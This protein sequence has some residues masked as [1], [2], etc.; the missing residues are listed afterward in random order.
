MKNKRWIEAAMERDKKERRKRLQ[1]WRMRMKN[2]KARLFGPKM[3]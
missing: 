1:T 2:K 3:H